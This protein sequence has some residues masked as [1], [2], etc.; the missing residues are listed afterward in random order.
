MDWA[1]NVRVDAATEMV[2]VFCQEAVVPRIRVIGPSV[3]E[4]QRID[5]EIEWGFLDAEETKGDVPDVSPGN[6]GSRWSP[7]A[8]RSPGLNQ[9]GTEQAEFEGRLESHVAIP[10]PVSPLAED[11]GTKVT[12][13]HAWQSRA[14]GGM[15][16]G[17]VLPVLY[18]PSSRPGVDSRITIWT[19]T[20]GVTFRVRDLE[21]GPILV[22]Q[23][24]IYVTKAGS[25]KTAR[26]FA[27]ELATRNLKS[28]RQMT[29]EHREAVSW[30]EVMKEVRLWTCPPGT[31]VPPLPQFQESPVQVELP[32]A[33]WSNAWHAAS[34]QLKGKHMWGGL[35]FE[36]GRV[37]HEMDL[38]GLHAE[39]DKVYEHFLNSPGAKSDGDY[40]DGTGALEWATA[41]RHDMGYSHDGTHASTGRLLFA[42]ADRYFLT[43]DKE[44]FQRHRV[45]LQAAADWILRQRALYLKEVPSRRELLVAGLMPPCMLGDYAIPSCDWHWYYVDNALAL[46][47]L[48]R[49]ADALAEFD[50]AAD[51][52]YRVE[53]DAFR[54]DIRRAVERDAALRRCGWGV[55]APTVVTSRGWRT[56]EACRGQNWALPNTR[57]AIVSWAHCRLLN[58]SRCSTQVTIAWSV[59]WT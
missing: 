7:F 38:V 59:P 41:M 28:V 3:G 49:F 33:G 53:A 27:A 18:A 9:R 24:G 44:W 30:D 14:V 37:A 32:D 31:V 15:R 16:R 40:T 57:T 54:H 12:G 17:I 1:Y 4:W 36:V 45:R 42:M 55:T 58:P 39:A 50:A 29:R 43:G 48:Q 20:A 35:A 51:R 25:G 19:K 2:A 5:L 26:Q 13:A 34:R 8:I 52:R 22:P 11:N 47:G 6:P 10:G 56:R 21:N 46:Q 23:H